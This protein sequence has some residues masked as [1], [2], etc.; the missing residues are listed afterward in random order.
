LIV[1]VSAPNVSVLLN[2]DSKAVSVT[3]RRRKKRTRK[4]V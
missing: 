2:A 3:H 4:K 1:P